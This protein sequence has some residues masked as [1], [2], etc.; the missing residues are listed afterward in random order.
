[1]P[2]ADLDLLKRRAAEVASLAKVRL[3]SWGVI[4]PSQLLR[5][6]P[7]TASKAGCA[8]IGP[9]PGVERRLGPGRHGDGVDAA[10]L[11]DK[12]DDRPARPCW[13]QPQL[14]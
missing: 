12:G 6:Y 8:V 9:G 11:A 10:V 2:Q 4:F 1:M 7:T 13:H 5:A 14:Q 3:R